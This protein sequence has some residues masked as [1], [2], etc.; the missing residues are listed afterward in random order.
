MRFHYALLLAAAPLAVCAPAVP[1][2]AQSEEP[3]E[4]QAES[5][6]EHNAELRAWFDAKYEEQVLDSP[7]TL[8]SLGRK[9]RY[10]EIDDFSLA[11]QDEDLAWLKATVEEMERTF[12][13]DSLSTADKLSYDLWKYE[14]ERAAESARWRENSYVFTQMHGAHTFLPSILISQHDV[15]PA[16]DMRD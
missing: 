9:E 3:V 13:Y 12:D 8:T 10:G 14:Y 2:F 5:A 7:L 6:P 16:Q 15:D 4:T 1:A 11:A